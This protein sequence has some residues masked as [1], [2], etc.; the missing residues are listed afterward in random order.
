MKILI[1]AG[2]TCEPIDPVRYLTNRSSGKMGYAIAAAAA[3]AGHR[4]LLISG[5][6]SL[7][8]PEGIDFLPVETAAEMFDAVSRY[9]PSMDAAIFAAAVAD[10]TPAQPA[11]Q[12]IKK[13]EAKLAGY[14]TPTH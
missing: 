5:P 6:T 3:H 7:D 12:K 1:T 11:T 4:V 14:R 10:Y 13:N 2:P 8:V 9:L